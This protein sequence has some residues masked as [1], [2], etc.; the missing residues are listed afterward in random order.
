M[1]GGGAGGGGASVA[2]VYTDP[3]NGMTFTD[4]AN[5]SGADALN[6]EI[7]SRQVAEKAASDAVDA[8]AA[9][10][11]IQDESD[12]QT[13]FS[14]AKTQARANTEQY[15]KQQGYDPTKY[16][17]EINNAITTAAGGV[18][19]LAPNPSAA[20]SPSLG[21]SILADINAGVQSRAGNTI[22]SL[23]APTY[24]ND[25][26]T[27]DWLAPAEDTVLTSQFDPLGAQLTNSFKRGTLNQT[28]YDAAHSKMEL[29][30]TAA[31]SILSGL[32]TNILNSDRGGVNSYISGA[33][34]DAANV[35]ALTFDSFD[36]TVYAKGADSMV[37][38]YH[39]NFAGDLTNAVGA[40]SFSD[41]SSL[42]NAGGAVQGATDPTATNPNGGAA[43]EAGVSDAY[44]AQQALAHQKRGLGS[45][46]SF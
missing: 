34:N 44:I 39:D 46:G 40:T 13:R 6:A 2:P 17:N 32:G 37:G 11:K 15:F 24:A 21:A 8:K 36:P 31:R 5:Q 29:D 25:R 18:Q 7:A 4:N 26:I 28:G 23:F 35:N 19:D 3:V 43:G 38:N 20:F 30:R 33:K 14:T 1:S 42:L 12:F 16:D 27:N 45:T 10:Q 9:A 41:L 22:K